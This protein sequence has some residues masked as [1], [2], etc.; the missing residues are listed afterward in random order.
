[1]R[2]AAVARDPKGVGMFVQVIEGKTKDPEALHERIEVWKRDLMPTA[3]GYL[4]STGGCT[5][6]GSCILIARFESADA[7]RRNSERPEQGEWWKETER[8]FDGPARFH[9]SED[10]QVMEHGSLDAAHF[11]QVM[12]GHVTDR[13]RA[14]ELEREAD[15]L[16][17]TAR[18]DLLGSVTAYFEDGEFTEVA[19][20]TSEDAAR[21]GEHQDMSPD[22]ASTFMQWQQVM[23]VDRYLDI[24]DPWL[25]SA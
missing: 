20:F 22:V 14:G 17:A 24:R 2:R 6:D 23:P 7:A 4:G 11:V 10:V 9:D 25:T 3:I 5:A 19:Y 8:L 16:L 12:E 1:L 15:T 21:A 18:P 13:D